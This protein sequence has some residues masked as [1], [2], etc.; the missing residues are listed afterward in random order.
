VWL[1]EG[2]AP[3]DQ[4]DGGRG[5]FPEGHLGAT[6]DMPTETLDDSTVKIQQQFFQNVASYP[7]TIDCEDF[8]GFDI[9]V[10]DQKH[11]MMSI[12]PHSPTARQ[13][14]LVIENEPELA[15]TLVSWL[16]ALRERKHRSEGAPNRGHVEA[17]T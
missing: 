14:T 17:M 12:M 16:M 15:S 8:I 11:V 10:V 6:T 9:L 7:T 1:P 3:H 2:E 13:I 5:R 4:A